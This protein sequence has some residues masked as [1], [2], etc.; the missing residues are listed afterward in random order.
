MREGLPLGRLISTPWEELDPKEQ[1]WMLYGYHGIS[2][3]AKGKA[4]H[5]A[6]YDGIIPELMNAY[7]ASKNPMVRKQYEKHMQI[8]TCASCQGAKLNDQARSI[9]LRTSAKRFASDPWL[10]IDQFSRLTVNECSEFMSALE[11]SELHWTIGREAI[12][13]IRARLQFLEDVGLGYLSLNRT[14]PTLSGGESQRIRLAS[15]I[16]SGL[17]GVMYVLDEP[18]IGLHPRDN[19][20]LLSSLTRL[21]NLGNTLIVVEHDEDTIR[22]ADT[23][24]DF[25]PGPGV[26][27]GRLIASGSVEDISN[28]PD[29]ITGGFLSG[30]RTIRS[31]KL[32]DPQTESES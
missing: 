29:S 24:V 13:E 3:K 18:S 11:L 9:R 27:G 17:V 31:P 1:R 20:R 19:D 25:G 14:A 10:S 28:N 2:V 7:R 21:R 5:G 16:G 23:V 8:T 26:K 4:S 32:D 22:L 30:T 15:Q 6:D 12:K